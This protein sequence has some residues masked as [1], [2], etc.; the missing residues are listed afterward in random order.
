M[1]ILEI[2]P[3][4]PAKNA[5]IPVILV[6]QTSAHNASAVFLLLIFMPSRASHNV[7]MAFSKIIYSVC[8]VT[9]IVPHAP[10]II[11]VPPVH[12]EHIY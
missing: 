8:H 4:F 9:T 2:S 6:L 10:H 5:Y 7:L 12:K 11:T 1:A 3:H